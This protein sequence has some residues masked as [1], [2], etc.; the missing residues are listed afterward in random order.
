M[1]FWQEAGRHYAEAAERVA[2]VWQAALSV[3][4]AAAVFGGDAEQRD[5]ITFPE[6]KADITGNDRNQSG[7]KR[8]AA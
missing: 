8:R 7:S 5:F 3:P 4:S 2:S 6:G 1:A